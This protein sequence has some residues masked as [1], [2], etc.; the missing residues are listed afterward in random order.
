M[1]APPARRREGAGGHDDRVNNM[2]DVYVSPPSRRDERGREEGRERRDYDGG[3]SRHRGRSRE[4]HREQ[5]RRDLDRGV[6]EQGKVVHVEH[7]S[8]HQLDP[9]R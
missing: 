4:D 5:G 9:P 3:D 2:R 8:S 1:Y 6:K 7:I